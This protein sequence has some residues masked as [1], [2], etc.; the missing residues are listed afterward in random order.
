MSDN[1]AAPPVVFLGPSATKNDV[2]S[3]LPNALIQPP[4]QRGDLYRFRILNHSLFVVIDGVFSNT[5][6]IS[7]REVVDVISD[8]AT[9]IGVSSMGALRAADCQPA[10]AF[11]YGNI[12]RLFHQ[13]IISSEDEVAVIYNPEVPYPPYSEPLINLRIALRRAKRKNLIKDKDCQ[14]IIFSANNLHYSERTWTAVFAGADFKPTSELIRYLKATDPKREDVVFAMK[15]IAT[16]LARGEYSSHPRKSGWTFGIN[17][18]D[19]E[20]P[21]DIFDGET[22]LDFRDSFLEW[23]ILSGQFHPY[24]LDRHSITEWLESEYPNDK[25]I[26]YQMVW[27]QVKDMAYL[28]A[29]LFRFHS[30][31][32]GSSEAKRLEIP[33]CR[34]DKSLAEVELSDTYQCRNWNELLDKLSRNSELVNSIRRLRDEVANCK[35]L[36]RALFRKNYGDQ[37]ISGRATWHRKQK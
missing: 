20:R 34:Q 8:G 32:R 36:K 37:T 6:S 1:N 24:S 7:P 28:G 13:Q 26:I 3:S 27:D 35:A 19:R 25:Q 16:R 31:R 29:L 9:F 22:G 14:R 11:G 15:R 4:V 30:F 10:G 17:E 5:L 33:I 18:E 23:L 2:L 12:F 21:P